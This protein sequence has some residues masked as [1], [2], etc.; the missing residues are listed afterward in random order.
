MKCDLTHEQ[1]RDLLAYEPETGLFRWRVDR[2]A[3]WHG[4][5]LNARA[6]DIAGTETERGYRAIRIDGRNYYA[7]RL[8]WLYMTGEWPKKQ[9]DHVNANRDDNRWE[10]LRAATSRENNWNSSKQKNNTTGFKGVYLDKRVNRYVAQIMHSGKRKH[11][12]MFSSAEKAHAA[13]CEAARAFH[14]EFWR[15]G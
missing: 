13:Y 1:L 8:A 15:A 9:I 4:K 2:G 14:G 10:N 3:A 7:H 5:I 11:L 6:G 12:G